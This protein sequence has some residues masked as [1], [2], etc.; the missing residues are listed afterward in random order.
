MA[1]I[2]D[3]FGQGIG[4]IR[5]QVSGAGVGGTASQAYHA[6]VDQDGDRQAG[7]GFL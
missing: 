5:H 6:F 1:K 4:Q 7:C 3:L 2:A